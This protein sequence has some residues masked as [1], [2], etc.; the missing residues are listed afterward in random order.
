MQWFGKGS[1]NME[2][3]RG[4][5]G[6]K[7]ALGGGIGII[8]V[9]IGLFLGKDLTGLVNQLPITSEQTE[10]KRGVPANDAQ[11]QFVSG[12]LESTEQ[13]WTQQFNELGLSYQ[14]PTLRLFE[15]GV[16]TACGGASSAV[17]PFYCPGD[18]KVYIDLSFFAELKNRFGAAG[19]FAQAYVIA[20]EVGH[21]V[22]NLL[23]TSEKVQRARR[24]LS[25]KE[26]NKLS[27]ML[28]LQADFYAG[29]WAHHA[30]N[31]KDFR[32][33]A[34]DL[35]E[36]LTAANAI[37]D[38]KLQKQ[39]TGEVVPDSFTHGTSAQRMYWFKKGFESGDFN[40]GD[41]FSTSR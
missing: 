23:G 3:G 35:E 27:V 30:Q 32:L 34:G 11:A 6:G 26:Y 22:Q 20:H 41:T 17:G 13:V 40:Q 28:E 9:I 7:V 4:G 37:G 24:N 14:Y 25:E 2:D 31:L 36:A 10:V 21:H 1:N 8:I 12:V 38:D 5:G 19:D 15:D 39:A 18:N 16:Q 33:D 29:L